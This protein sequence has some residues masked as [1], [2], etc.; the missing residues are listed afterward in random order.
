MIA[1]SNCHRVGSYA[2]RAAWNAAN[3]STSWRDE[4]AESGGK[5]EESLAEF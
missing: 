2:E 1:R 3:Y 5:L 4:R